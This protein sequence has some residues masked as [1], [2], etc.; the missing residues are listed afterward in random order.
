M[1][2]L[3]EADAVFVFL[4]PR[5]MPKLREK[6]ERELKPGA[7]VVCYSWP[8]PGWQPRAVDD[9]PGRPKIYLYE[10]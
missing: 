10:R 4:M 8:I 5:I 9:A 6:M 2:D 1:V 7:R 3:K